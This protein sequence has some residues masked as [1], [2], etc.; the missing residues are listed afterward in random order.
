MSTEEKKQTEIEGPNL[1]Q[2]LAPDM[3]KKT[4]LLVVNH[5][6]LRYHSFDMLRHQLYLDVKEKDFE[7]FSSL[8]ETFRPFWKV[9]KYVGDQVDLLRSECYHLNVFECFQKSLSVDTLQKYNERILQMVQSG[10]SHITPTDLGI[11]L[12]IVFDRKDVTGFVL[13]HKGEKYKPEW[14][15]KVTVYETDDILDPNGETIVDLI[16]QQNI[17]AVFLPDVESIIRTVNHMVNRGRTEHIT[18]IHAN[19]AYNY[20][21]KNGMRLRKYGELLDLIERTYRHEMGVFDPFTGISTM[22]NS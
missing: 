7:H 2:T 17:N 20:E 16:E 4:R 8:K 12:G 3:M 10:E 22:K 14:Y 6:T 1:F 9:E 11:R 15:H 13:Q 19:Y 18:F 21:L 5:D